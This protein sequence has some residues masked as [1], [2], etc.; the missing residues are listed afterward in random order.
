MTNSYW[1]VCWGTKA[2]RTNEVPVEGD[3]GDEIQFR[4][5]A[6]PGYDGTQEFFF[7]DDRQPASIRLAYDQAVACAKSRPK[8]RLSV[9]R[10]P[11]VNGP[12]DGVR[13]VLEGLL[14]AELPS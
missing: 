14:G 3:L 11:K 12:W 6:Q 10:T 5:A 13:S 2:I 8:A 4:H 1:K 9:W 7:F